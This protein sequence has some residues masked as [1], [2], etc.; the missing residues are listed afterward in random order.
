VSGI[1]VNPVQFINA[2]MTNFNGY[3]CEI[4]LKSLFVHY[5]GK[6]ALGNCSVGG[7][8]GEIENFEDIKWPTKPVIC[9]KNVC[10]CS[11][12]VNISK[13]IRNYKEYIQ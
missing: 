6:I 4:G 13:W 11:T 3:V 2:G 12:D 5:N 8:I 9:T 7:Y 10:H 1:N